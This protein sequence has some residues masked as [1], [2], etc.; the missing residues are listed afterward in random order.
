MGRYDLVGLIGER[1]GRSRPTC[2]SDRGTGPM[3][4]YLIG[5]D[6]PRGD[7]KIRVPASAGMPQVRRGGGR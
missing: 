6:H 7:T 3:N 5:T 1:V 4:G 2:G